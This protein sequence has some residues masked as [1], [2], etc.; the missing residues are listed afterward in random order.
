MAPETKTE[1][2]VHIAPRQVWLAIL[3]LFLL[4][5]VLARTGERVVATGRYSSPGAVFRNLV[6]TGDPR[7]DAGGVRGVELAPGGEITVLTTLANVAGRV[8]IGPRPTTA[9]TNYRVYVAGNLQVTGCIVLNG[10]RRCDW[11]E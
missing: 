10:A 7:A 8:D 1:I 4:Y 5:P 6:V 9:P 3:I 11:F 2:V